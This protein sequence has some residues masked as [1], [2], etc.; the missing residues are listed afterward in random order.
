[1]SGVGEARRFAIAL[2]EAHAFSEQ[3]TP[4]GVA[5]IVTFEAASNT[6]QHGGGGEILLRAWASGAR[7]CCIEVL[8]LDKGPGMANVTGV[9]A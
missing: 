2:A 5:L 4:G 3:A 9:H 7:D 6:V 8:A 1:M